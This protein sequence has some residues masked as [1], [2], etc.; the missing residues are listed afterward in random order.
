MRAERQHPPIAELLSLEN[1]YSAE[2]WL[3]F[4]QLLRPLLVLQRLPDIA[5][6]IESGIYLPPHQRMFLHTAHLGSSENYYVCSRGTAKTSTV[7]ALYSA[8]VGMHY[9][10]RNMITLSATGFRGGQQIFEELQRWIEGGWD[11]QNMEV[12]FVAGSI[13]RTPPVL[14]QQNYWSMKFQSH[15]QNVTL[16]TNK[17]DSIRGSRA[18]DL[19]IDEAMLTDKVF[20]T[21]IVEPFL[22]VTDDHRHGGAYASTNRIFYLTTVDY[23]WRPFMD[24]VRAAKASMEHDYDAFR[25][26]RVG[27]RERYEK[28]ANKGFCR[29]ML[30]QYDYT[31]VLIR[32]ELTT[33]DGRKFKVKYTDDAIPI[34]KDPRG[35]PYLVPDEFGRH[36]R[37][38]PPA[39]Y[40]Q[41]YAIAKSKLEDGL[42]NGSAEESIWL[43]EQ[44]NIL[45]ETSGD[46]YPNI[47]IDEIECRGDRVIVPYKRLPKA[48]RDDETK[49]DG[50]YGY[51]GPVL[52]R[53][54]SPCVVGVDYAPIKAF[55][56]FVVIR[57]GPL[58]TGDFDPFSHI[59]NTEWSNVIWA[60]QH[61]QMTFRDMA[62]KLWDFRERYNLASFN[63]PGVSPELACRAIG[64][65][66]RHGG[67]GVRD[68]LAGFAEAGLPVGI[69]R[70]YD[71]LDPDS[72]IREFHR[73]PTAEP[74]LDC[75]AAQDPLNAALVDYSLAQMQQRL[76]FLPKWVDYTE[77]P[78][79][80]SETKPGYEATKLLAQQLRKLRQKPTQRARNFYMDNDAEKDLWSAFI[81]A[82]KQLRA[83]MLR[84]AQ[85]NDAPPPMIGKVVQVGSKPGLRQVRRS[86]KRAIGAK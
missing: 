68:E 23:G 60:E 1:E 49:A 42:F 77:R 22:N 56:A 18:K 63:D 76:L 14:R 40:W 47:L 74:I 36:R 6:I 61:R 71:P 10:R 59:G 54:N 30:V 64:L 52:Y 39:S 13:P 38:Q 32:T 7:A 65:D 8:F 15:S 29:Q 83:H 84:L 55:C 75:I 46:V 58:D 17:E 79:G 24:K 45:D 27:D 81:Y 86:S 3:E 82:V 78:A 31:D 57:I 37:E 12:P 9:P 62:A 85:L 34:T 69:P 72:R 44:R 2:E 80:T 50:E 66:V 43:A 73:D 51:T 5:L 48:W 21:K 25:A 33:R 70:I 11:S 16:P 67:T 35:I 4:S 41:T 26:K 20:L 28:L 19:W 53:C